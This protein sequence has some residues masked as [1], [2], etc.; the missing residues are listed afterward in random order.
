MDSDSCPPGRRDLTVSGVVAVIPTLPM[1]GNNPG[2]RI[3]EMVSGL[4]LG[5]MKQN[6]DQ[7]R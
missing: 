4:L 6:S 2:P 5:G 7:R 3:V 1:G